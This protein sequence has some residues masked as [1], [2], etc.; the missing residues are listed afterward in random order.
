M[1]P[2]TA[3]SVRRGS[4]ARWACV[5]GASTPDAGVSPGDH[6]GPIGPG[7]DAGYNPGSDGGQGGSPDAGRIH[8]PPPRPGCG[9][10][11]TGGEGAPSWLWGLGALAFLV[12]R[13]RR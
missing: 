6:A 4:A 9:C 8:G 10:R 13:R 11:A 1:T 12:R 2:A 5:A 3:R 7:Y